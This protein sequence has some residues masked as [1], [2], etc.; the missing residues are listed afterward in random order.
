MTF[1][2]QE[3]DRFREHL[4]RRTG[5]WFGDAKRYY[6]E[7]RAAER[8]VETGSHDVADYFARLRVD[9]AE[10]QALVNAFTVNETYFYRE[11]HQLACLGR[12]LLPDI[13]STRRPGD[14]VRIWSAPCSTG[15]E[16]Y[17]IALWLLENW[18]MVDAYNVE[19]VGSDIDSQALEAARSG[20]YAERALA[21]LPA[22]VRGA[23]F[24]PL[25]RHRWKIIDDLR[26]SVTFTHANLMESA[27]L[28]EQGLFDI[29][30]CRNV[31]IYFDDASREIAAANLYDRLVPGGYLC[32]GHTESMSR[33][34]DRFVSRRFDDAIVFQ[35]P[36]VPS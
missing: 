27:G 14:K 15:E 19:I 9:A 22:A 36:G 32:L 30:F 10:R 28:G 7:R 13:V 12:T 17:S 25:K 8:L 29:I 35:R 26:E 5:M 2:D 1:T 6:I 4:Y 23:Y 33:I 24:E 18:R 31:L 11:E 34:D 21:R 16:P 3:I 20:I